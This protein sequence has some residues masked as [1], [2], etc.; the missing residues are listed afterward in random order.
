MISQVYIYAILNQELLCFKSC[1]CSGARHIDSMMKQIST[2]VI[3][4]I[5]VCTMVKQF[6]NLLVLSSD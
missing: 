5:D 4:L 6:L 3:D 2:L 1:I